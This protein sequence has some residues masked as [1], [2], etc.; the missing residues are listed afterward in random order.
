MDNLS[1]AVAFRDIAKECSAF[2]N[3]H[4]DTYGLH[5]ITRCRTLC[6][7]TLIILLKFL[8][9]SFSETDY[10]QNQKKLLKCLPG[11]LLLHPYL[12]M[13]RTSANYHSDSIQID[14]YE[15]TGIL[16]LTLYCLKRIHAII[17]NRGEQELI[18]F[19]SIFES[20]D[21]DSVPR[22]QFLLERS[23]KHDF[24]KIQ[25][26]ETVSFLTVA[27]ESPKNS[28]PTTSR[29]T[30]PREEDDLIPKMVGENEKGT[31]CMENAAGLNCEY[32]GCPRTHGSRTT[33]YWPLT[34]IGTKQC[35]RGHKCEKNQKHLT[36][37]NGWIVSICPDLHKDDLDEYKAELGRRWKLFSEG[38]VKYDA[39][40]K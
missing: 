3:S 15:S 12:E 16:N 11:E 13:V 17:L 40:F 10:A 35:C 9:E 1:C 38:K 18:V 24:L 23:T 27:R 5:T 39:M 19:R 14:E 2:Q 29:E 20:I 6:Q 31:P 36:M 32:T 7:H 30:S 8:G 21:I 4:D 22:K 28:P 34:K 33:V 25:P 26:R 37:K